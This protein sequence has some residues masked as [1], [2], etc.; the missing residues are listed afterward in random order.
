MTTRTILDAVSGNNPNITDASLQLSRFS[1][2]GDLVAS[3]AR[4]LRENSHYT[5]LE[6]SFDDKDVTF[7]GD[8]NWQPLL[9]DVATREILH[10][11]SFF[12]DVPSGSLLP[13]FRN[14]F[15]QALRRNRSVRVVILAAFD[16]SNNNAD[17]LLAYLEDSSTNLNYLEIMDDCGGSEGGRNVATALQRNSNINFLRLSTSD[18]DFVASMFQGLASSESQSRLKTIEF[19]VD[20]DGLSSEVMQAWRQYLESTS[21]TLLRVSDSTKLSL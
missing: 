3:V 1:E 7:P 17:A 14:Q 6:F 18:D 2:E 8:M 13:F 21:A 4:V 10:A 9:Q 11:V 12:D 19:T 20:F 16:C 5:E 15:F